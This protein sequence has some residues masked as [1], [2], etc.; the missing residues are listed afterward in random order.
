MLFA[1]YS[2]KC[3]MISS[4]KVVTMPLR[5]CTFGIAGPSGSFGSFGSAGP[6]ESSAKSNS[7]PE[8]PS[9]GCSRRWYLRLSMGARE[10]IVV[11]K[12]QRGM[13][14]CKCRLLTTTQSNYLNIHPR[15]HIHSKKWKWNVSGQSEGACAGV[16]SLD[17]TRCVSYANIFPIVKRLSDINHCL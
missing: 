15:L 3:F 1:S 2:C 13:N 14:M 17:H 16:L 7:K 5:E 11:R 12:V 6:P 8:C 9:E 4:W 10:R